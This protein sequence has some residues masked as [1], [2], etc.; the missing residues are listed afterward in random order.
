MHANS[1][2]LDSTDSTKEEASSIL[3]LRKK[4]PKVQATTKDI[5]VSIHVALFTGYWDGYGI[6]A[7]MLRW[8]WHKGLYPVEMLRL[9]RLQ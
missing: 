5:H 8:S 2:L 9:E 7:S 4:R 3:D 6:S 1:K